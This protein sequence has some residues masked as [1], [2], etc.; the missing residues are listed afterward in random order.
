MVLIY[1]IET[2]IVFEGKPWSY[3]VL[4]S[5]KRSS[6]LDD[7]AMMWLCLWKRGQVLERLQRRSS[8]E[9]ALA[10]VQHQHQ[11]Q[12]G[13]KR[14]FWYV[15][16]WL[17]QSHCV[18]ALWKSVW[19]FS[20]ARNCRLIVCCLGPMMSKCEQHSEEHCLKYK[21]SLNHKLLWSVEV[22][23]SYILQVV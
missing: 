22:S 15:F 9:L 7:D 19:S 14:S 23:D 8:S 17:F 16:T 2:Y 1:N 10:P 20:V 11:F 18:S 13:L 4:S 21:L 12:V 6:A 5:M 3:T